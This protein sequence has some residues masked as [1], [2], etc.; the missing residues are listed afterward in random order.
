MNIKISK[1]FVKDTQAIT[2]QRILAKIKKIIVEAQA[3][4]SVYELSH[5]T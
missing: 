2:D 4:N 3:V 5:I 1:R